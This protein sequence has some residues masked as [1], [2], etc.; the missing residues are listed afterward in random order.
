M[1]AGGTSHSLSVQ[2][3]SSLPVLSGRADALGTVPWGGSAMAC[4]PQET[5][6][7]AP[8][9]WGW[10][11]DVEGR[12]TDE[13]DGS[14]SLGVARGGPNWNHLLPLAKARALSGSGWRRS[15]CA[16]AGG[17]GAASVWTATRAAAWP[18]SPR[19][20]PCPRAGPP[21][22]ACSQPQVCS[23][24][25]GRRWPSLWRTLAGAAAEILR[26]RQRASG[27]PPH[28]APA[29]LAVFK[30]KRHPVRE[31]IEPLFAP[32]L[33]DSQRVLGLE[34]GGE[35]RLHRGLRGGWGRLW[36][37]WLAGDWCGGQEGHGG[38]H[39]AGGAGR[40]A[41]GLADGPVVEEEG[42]LLDEQ[43][44]DC[45]VGARGR[46]RVHGAEV[47][48]HQR[49][50]EADG[51]VLT[52]HEVHLVVVADSVGDTK[53]RVRAPWDSE[54]WSRLHAVP[55]PMYVLTVTVTLAALP[56]CPVEA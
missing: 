54:P 1:G 46:E 29:D 22:A 49:G 23:A 45:L 38:G 56:G 8:S 13:P 52:G 20:G 16:W 25:L 28:P 40:G 51:Q 31:K 32:G 33:G 14:V 37:R 43:L 47:W 55:C 18:V 4:V 44:D 12:E 50:P 19:K 34:L 11:T 26:R 15:W 39:G 42:A 2:A 53:R 36:G 17:P 5:A 48:P 21:A 27:Q 24:G 41:G 10:G 3:Q 35:Q 30:T 6:G 9:R 7:Q